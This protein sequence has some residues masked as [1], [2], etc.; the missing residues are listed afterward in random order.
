M[1][2]SKL[3]TH[4]R[5]NNKESQKHLEENAKKFSQQ[6]L[7]VLEMLNQGVRLTVK[8]AVN[9]GISSLPRRI[10]DLRDR[11]GIDYI[12]EEWVTDSNGK[13]LYKEW[14]MTIT[15]RPTKAQVV[16]RHSEKGKQSELFDNNHKY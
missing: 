10:K 15:K 5:E 1:K 16:K 12:Q 3:H 14:F 2:E 6:C 7:M 9:N 11:N 13:R 8:K 4:L